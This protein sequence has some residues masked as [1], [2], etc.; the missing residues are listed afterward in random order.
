MSAEGKEVIH[1]S[2]EEK[3]D[4]H[5]KITTLEILQ[6][7]F[8]RLPK[9][10]QV[11]SHVTSLCY[12]LLKNSPKKMLDVIPLTLKACRVCAMPPGVK[13]APG[14]SL[15]RA[16]YEVYIEFHGGGATVTELDKK[17]EKFQSWMEMSQLLDKSLRL[18]FE[19]AKSSRLI[20]DAV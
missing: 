20:V 19:K 17:K 7:A 14:K 12:D 4:T 5:T 3:V 1:G 11:S 8:K 10:E 9:H 13:F 18:V 15:M 6:E 16:A 2:G